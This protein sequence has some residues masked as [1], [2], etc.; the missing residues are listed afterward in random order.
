LSW[1]QYLSRLDQGF[2][3]DGNDRGMVLEQLQICADAWHTFL[4]Y[5]QGGLL[6]Q[7]C[8]EIRV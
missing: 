1:A 8:E 5:G 3:C 6:G 4:W 2:F 7:D